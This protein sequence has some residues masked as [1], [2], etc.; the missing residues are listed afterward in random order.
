V[1]NSSAMVYRFAS[2]ELAGLNGPLIMA[3]GSRIRNSRAGFSQQA[4]VLRLQ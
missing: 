1:D 2:D 3:G 4:I